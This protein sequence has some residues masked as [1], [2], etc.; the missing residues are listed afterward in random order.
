[1]KKTLLF[2]LL[3]SITTLVYSQVNI[4]DANFKA[5]LVGNSAINTNGDTEIQ[6]LEATNFTGLLDCSSLIISSLTGVEAFVNITKLYCDSNQLNYLDVSQ[7]TLLTELRCGYNQLTSLD[8]S[9]NTSLDALNCA[10]NQLSNLD[11]SQNTLLTV[12]Q[13]SSNQIASIN[14]GLT[15]ELV[16]LYCNSN[17]LMSLDVGQNILLTHLHCYTNQLTSLDLSQNT[18]LTELLCL[19]NQLTG[20]NL[21]NGNNTNIT[22]FNSEN[23]SNLTCILVDDASYSTTNWTNIDPASTFVNSQA[24]CNALSTENYELNNSFSIYP[25]PTSSHLNIYYN[26]SIDRVEIYN[27]LGKKVLETDTTTTTTTTT[28]ISTNSLTRGV[29]FIKLYS[30]NKLGLKRFVKQ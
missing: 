28:T 24:E 29:Y 11:V 12:L 8:V 7:N 17:Q 18:S 15:T 26:K 30:G 20:L 14:L 23:N 9:Q 22:L 2:L 1:M 10:G 27:I 16:T 13:C 19:G 25:N 3:S 6:V 21:L 4:P 5:Y